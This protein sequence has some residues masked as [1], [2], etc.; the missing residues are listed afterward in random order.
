MIKPLIA[1]VSGI[2]LG[3]AGAYGVSGQFGGAGPSIVANVTVRP[4]NPEQASQAKLAPLDQGFVNT[5]LDNLLALGNQAQAAVAKTDPSTTA[6]TTN[7]ENVLNDVQQQVQSTLQSQFVTSESSSLSAGAVTT[8]SS[9]NP[10]SSLGAASVPPAVTTA[11]NSALA[12][13][14]DAYNEAVARAATLDLPADV[15]A[16]LAAFLDTLRAQLLS[17]SLPDM[18]N[19][20]QPQALT[21]NSAVDALNTFL[22][23][24]NGI[25]MAP[26]A[27]ATT[28]SALL[29]ALGGVPGVNTSFPVATI[30]AATSPA[31]TIAQNSASVFAAADA[32]N[33]A[34]INQALANLDAQRKQ[35]AALQSQTMQLLSSGQM[36]TNP[37]GFIDSLANNIMQSATFTSH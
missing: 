17:L 22:A 7:L 24:V 29:A 30:T 11:A 10:T 1:A 25:S 8:A 28:F 35:S 4:I 9:Y 12:Q 18:L 13:A 27:K 2:A 36:F 26:G 3:L 21:S 33:Q 20:A 37:Q 16:D 31:P 32:Q 6:T 5:T 14:I 34:A 15:E 23:N 19:N